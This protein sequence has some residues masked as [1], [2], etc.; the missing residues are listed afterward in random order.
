MVDIYKD[1]WKTEKLVVSIWLFLFWKT[2]KFVFALSEKQKRVT[3][4]FSG[5]RIVKKTY[6]DSV[7]ISN[8]CR[9]NLLQGFHGLCDGLF[10]L[11]VYSHTSALETVYGGS[12]R[13]E[14][15]FLARACVWLHPAPAFGWFRG[16][17]DL[18]GNEWGKNLK[19]ARS[20]GQRGFESLFPCYIL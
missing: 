17:N 9:M 16:I 20:Y 18:W 8:H 4:N 14:W 2:E 1:F 12:T 15:G 6:S 10:L 7:F 11:L 13:S 3:T 5:K 19:K